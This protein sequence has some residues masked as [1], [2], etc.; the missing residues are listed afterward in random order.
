MIIPH[1]RLSP[2][3][4]TALVEEFASRDG[5]DYGAAEMSLAQ[6]TRQLLQQLDQGHIVIVY[7]EST[8]SCNI[9]PRR[10]ARVDSSSE[11]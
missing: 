2:D 9:I 5:T 4:L 10:D 11:E 7:D 8:E 1:Q 6:K 3:T